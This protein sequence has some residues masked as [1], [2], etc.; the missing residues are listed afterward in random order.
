MMTEISTL[1]SDNYGYYSGKA[2][3]GSVIRALSSHS[4]GVILQS[5]LFN[6]LNEPFLNQDIKVVQQ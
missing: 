6:K 5:L 2:Y 4:N 3:D 1:A